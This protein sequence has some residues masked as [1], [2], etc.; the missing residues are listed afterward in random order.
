M[1]EVIELRAEETTPKT[2][3]GLQHP[4][5]LIRLTTAGWE[6]VWGC[7]PTQERAKEECQRQGFTHNRILHINLPPMVIE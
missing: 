2:S 4:F 5:M 3:K 7:Y 6:E 1:I